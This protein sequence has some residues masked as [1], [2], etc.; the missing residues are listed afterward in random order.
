MLT[1]KHALAVVALLVACEAA[2]GEVG[3]RDH[4]G[5]LPL[6]ACTCRAGG[7]DSLPDSRLRRAE[8]CPR[9]TGGGG[10]VLTR[11]GIG[12]T[13]CR[14]ASSAKVRLIAHRAVHR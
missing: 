7:A 14:R 6:A 13:P 8:H 1:I 12:D 5:A 9:F 2:G 10:V 3:Q 4:A 11:Q